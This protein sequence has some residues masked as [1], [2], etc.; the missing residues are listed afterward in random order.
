MNDGYDHIHP[1]DPCRKPPGYWT[2]AR[3]RQAA[4]EC[5]ATNIK[6]WERRHYASNV[7][8]RREGHTK[9]IATSLGWEIEQQRP[10]GHWRN[11]QN[12]LAVARDVQASSSSDFQKKD[13]AAYQ[14]AFRS[15][16]LPRLAV[17]MNWNVRVVDH[18]VYNT[19]LYFYRHRSYFYVGV[20]N[21]PDHRHERHEKADN[22]SVVHQY[23]PTLNPCYLTRYSHY[24]DACHPAVMTRAVALRA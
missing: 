11:Y 22:G 12:C 8:A 5:G 1:L 10:A 17:D 7:A 16:F 23:I 21:N 24:D 18:D 15:G 6:G 3:C 9:T 19:Q 2:Y 4:A 14:G 13:Q 20:T